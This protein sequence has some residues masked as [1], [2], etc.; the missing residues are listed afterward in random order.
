MPLARACR[1]FHNSYLV[2]KKDAAFHCLW[3]VSYTHLDVYKRQ[4][5]RYLNQQAEAGIPEEQA[6]K[7]LADVLGI[8]Y[9]KLEK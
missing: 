6:L 5:Q 9:P 4:M 3:H 8:S 7:N 2:S 1:L